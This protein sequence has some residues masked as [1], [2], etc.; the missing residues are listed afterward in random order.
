MKDETEIIDGEQS[1]DSSKE[2]IYNV[3]SSWQP[4]SLF[5][6]PAK[7]EEKSFAVKKN[8][9]TSTTQQAKSFYA[10]NVDSTGQKLTPLF[11]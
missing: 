3:R 6:S 7:R 8:S 9:A 10:G 5:Q 2:L 4:K 1:A 11:S